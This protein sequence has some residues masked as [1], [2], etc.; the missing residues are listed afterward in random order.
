MLTFVWDIDDVL[1][2]LMRSWFTEEWLP[3]HPECHL[4]YS[5]LLENPPHRVLGIPKQEYLAS[6][7]K[8][9]L[10]EKAQGMQPNASILGWL[11]SY[12][13]RHR[14]MALTARPLESIPCLAEWL[15]RHFGN[16]MR[17]FGV[18]PTRLQHGVPRYD[19]NKG[20][21]LRWFGKADCLIDD[22]EENIAAAQ[23]LGI[24]SVLYPQPWNRNAETVDETLRRL[25]T[26]A[27][28]N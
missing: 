6:L 20:D 19:S 1:N 18:V 13:A 21:Y 11:Q 9:R 24:G 25:A 5:G 3:G 23:S 10:S 26:L 8:F 14:H 15:F 28:A 2:D 12:G 17:D 27:E 4:T 22:S 16:Y 7:D